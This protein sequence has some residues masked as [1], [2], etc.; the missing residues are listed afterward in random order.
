MSLFHFLVGACHFGHGHH[1]ADVL[2]PDVDAATFDGAEIDNPYLPF[3][4]GATWYYES[5]TDAGLETIDVEVL[6]KTKTIEGV[7]AT[8]V[9]DTAHVDGVLTEDTYDWYA[10]DTD[11]NVWYL[12]EDTC[13][14]ED[15]KCVDTSGSWTWG[16]DGAVPGIVMWADPTV[17][18]QPYYQEYYEGEAE[19][20][21]EVIGVGLSLTVEAGSFEDCVETHDTSTLERSADEYKYFCAGVGNVL[22][23]EPDVSEELISYTGL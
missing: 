14:Y 17:D 6:A 3:P 19:D 11:G 12:G 15:D 9:R 7:E 8:I 16:V 5:D 18:G 21:G 23:D 10:Q 4:V 20:V 22:S 2:L 13:E 1:G